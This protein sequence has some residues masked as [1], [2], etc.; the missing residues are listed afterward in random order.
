LVNHQYI[1]PAA[2]DYSFAGGEG[3]GGF[4]TGMGGQLR[5]GGPSA[6]YTNTVHINALDAKSFADLAKSDPTA[7]GQAVMT[8]ITDSG[9]E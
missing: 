8:G 3:G 2:R 9:K 7:F 6:N 1:R 5:A 4:S